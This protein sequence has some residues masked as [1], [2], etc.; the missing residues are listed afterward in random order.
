MADKQH[1][2]P[3]HMTMKREWRA[4]L[5]GRL[6]QKRTI[7]RSR[8]KAARLMRKEALRAQHEAESAIGQM[9]KADAREFAKLDRRLAVLEGRLAS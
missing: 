6:K 9:E 2:R 3:K 8:I 7:T 1:E 4:E 5:R